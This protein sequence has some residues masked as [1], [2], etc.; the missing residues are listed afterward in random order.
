MASSKK[1]YS[2]LEFAGAVVGEEVSLVLV[3]VVD[4]RDC[5][6]LS[7][8]ADWRNVG[9]LCSRWCDCSRILVDIDADNDD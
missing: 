1:E 5:T 4:Q 9:N 6:L 2:V 8:T 3:L 7:S